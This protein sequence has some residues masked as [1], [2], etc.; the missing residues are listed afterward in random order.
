MVIR[1][2]PNGL[3]VIAFVAAISASSSS[4]V[5][6][7]QAITPKPP[8]L[9]I[10]LTRLRSLTQLIAPQRIAYSLPRKSVPRRISASVLLYSLMPARLDRTRRTG[11]P[12]PPALPSMIDK[13]DY[14]KT[15]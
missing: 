13:S 12:S 1:F 8:A 14:H 9:E 5:I 6:A 15:Y 7:P 11:K 3:S 2:T 4:G 10:A